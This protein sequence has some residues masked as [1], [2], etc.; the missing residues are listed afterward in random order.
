MFLR[1]ILRHA[2]TILLV[3]SAPLVHAITAPDAAVKVNVTHV[4]KDSW[5]VDYQFP[6]AVTAIKLAKVGEYRSTAWNILTPRMRMTTDAELDV[7]SLGGKPFRTLSV[8]ID[9]YNGKLQKFYA[10]F[11]G[12]TDGGVALFL[13]HLQ[14]D[15]Q[16]GKQSA[17]M[18]TDIRLTGLGQEN[19]IAPPLNKLA[20]G[21]ERGYAYFGPAKP[22]RSGTTVFLIDPQTPDWARETVLDTGAA[23]GRY[24]EKAYQRPL[25]DEMFV[26]VG[27][28]GFDA[29]GLSLNGGAVLGQLAY[30]FEGKQ[31]IGDHPKKRELLTKIV[32]HEMAHLWQMNVERGGVGGNNPWVHEGGA[33]AMA[34]EALQQTGLW[35]TEQITAYRAAQRASCDKLGDTVTSY[36]GIYACGLTRFDKLG[37]DIV[38]LWRA[39]IVATEVKGDPYSQEMIEAIV[40]SQ[41]SSLATH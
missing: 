36:E 26:M 31:L 38:A 12:F 20:P 24:Y 1:H 40:A 9:R 16:R 28:V 18:S 17:A 3:L 33:E 35:N 15:V 29:P 25:K 37:V 2:T 34:L 4:A 6:Q 30:R 32:A 27:I 10:P 41:G 13:G 11:N 14:G 8:E 22:Y 39:M 21:G 23:M 19:V 5:R 7:I